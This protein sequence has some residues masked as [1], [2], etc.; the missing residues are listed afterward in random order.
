MEIIEPFLIAWTTGTSASE[1][2]QGDLS[3]E[4]GAHTPRPQQ[5]EV[6]ALQ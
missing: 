4:S 6:I 1:T 5:P 3:L 2:Q